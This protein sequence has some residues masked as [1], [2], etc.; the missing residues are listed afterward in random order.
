MTTTQAAI[1]FAQMPVLGDIA[2]YH[3]RVRPGATGLALT[4]SGRSV[5][6]ADGGLEAFGL[7]AAQLGCRLLLAGAIDAGVALDVIGR[8]GVEFVICDASTLRGLCA[9]QAR[10]PRRLESL[11][12]VLLTDAGLVDGSHGEARARLGCRIVGLHGAA[13]TSGAIA[14]TAPNGQKV[15]RSGATCRLIPGMEAS[16]RD[17]RT[18]A[19]KAVGAPG[20][21][22][23][24]GFATMIGYNRDA[25]ATAAA[26]QPDGWLRTGLVG[27]MDPDGAMVLTGRLGEPAADRAA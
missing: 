17:P 22:C 7:G 1:D 9:A 10:R 24:R 15:G 6:P 26:I 16:I 3:A 5:S 18:N 23:V 2:R 25:A 21:V 12:V 11:E 27:A 19:I 13:E 8:E 20:E 4:V 14:L